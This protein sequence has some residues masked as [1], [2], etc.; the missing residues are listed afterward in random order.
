MQGEATNKIQT[1][2]KMV[3]YNCSQEA[4][5]GVIN[6]NKFMKHNMLPVLG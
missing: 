1:N 4:E 2:K 3:N 5:R 6:P